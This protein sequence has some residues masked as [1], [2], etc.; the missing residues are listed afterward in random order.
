MDSNFL[1]STISYFYRSDLYDDDEPQNLVN[2]VIRALQQVGSSVHHFPPPC[3]MLLISERIFHFPGAKSLLSER[4]PMMTEVSAFF[5]YTIETS[6][7]KEDM[8]LTFGE[9]SL[10]LFPGKTR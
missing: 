3:G 8:D 2:A 4:G 7:R 1:R 9:L 10:T 5:T 6:D